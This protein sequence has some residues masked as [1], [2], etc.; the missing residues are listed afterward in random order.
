MDDITKLSTALNNAALDPTASGTAAAAAAA[1]SSVPSSLEANSTQGTA[2]QNPQPAQVCGFRNA[3][4]IADDESKKAER[5]AN[6]PRATFVPAEATDERANRAEIQ[7]GTRYADVTADVSVE[8]NG[9]DGEREL[10]IESFEHPRV[11]PQLKHNIKTVKGWDKPTAVQSAVIPL[12]LTKK[13]D[14]MVHAPTGQGKTAAFLIPLI[15]TI[16][17]LKRQL[18]IADGA[19]NS[20]SPFAIIFLHTRDLADQVYAQASQLVKG[21]DNVKVAWAYGQTDMKEQRKELVEGCDIVCFTEGRA[22]MLLA[23]KLWKP[24]QVRYL[25]IDEADKLLCDC[26]MMPKVRDDIKAALRWAGHRPGGLSPDPGSGRRFSVDP[27]E[28]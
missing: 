24:D 1:E 28:A 22:R 14:M 6:A 3:G 7:A 19:V 5:K 17:C 9:G 4:F 11:L 25:V 26:D 23:Q 18:K 15:Q 12:I 10:R 13:H 21:I 20:D 2:A 8:V 27:R 16:S